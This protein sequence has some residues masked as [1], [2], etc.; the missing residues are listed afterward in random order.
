[1][2]FLDSFEGLKARTGWYKFST[3]QPLKWP[4]FVKKEKILLML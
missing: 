3:K 4:F 2:H 1:M